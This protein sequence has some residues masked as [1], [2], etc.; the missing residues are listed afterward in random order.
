ME[1]TAEHPEVTIEVKAAEYPETTKL[2]SFG[3]AAS[4]ILFERLLI[5]S[6][7]ETCMLNVPGDKVLGTMVI[8]SSSSC[9]SVILFCIRSY[10][11]WGNG[12][13]CSCVNMFWYV[14]LLVI[15]YVL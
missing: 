6:L 12:I 11:G 5:P 8:S 10:S 9:S 13:L 4:A 3:L 2:V 1:I 15:L 14:I 7:C